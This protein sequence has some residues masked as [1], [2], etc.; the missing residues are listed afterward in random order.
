MAEHPWRH[1]GFGWRAGQ[2][3]MMAREGRYAN[4][5]TV[6]GELARERLERVEERRLLALARGSDELCWEADDEPEPLVTVRYTTYN[7]G[8]AIERALASALRQTYERLEVLVVGD[9]CDEATARAVQAVRDPRVRFVNLPVRGTYP[10]YPLYRW[11]IAGATPMNVAL[12]IASGK[13]IAPSDDDDELTDDHVEVL[14]RHARERRHEFVWSQAESE[15]KEMELHVV[16]SS[17]LTFGQIIHGTV[18]YST[19][20]RF[21]RYSPTSWKLVEGTDWNL[22]RRMQRAGVRMGFLP[23]VTYRKFQGVGQAG[24]P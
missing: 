8:P 13:W 17:P 2:L 7:R 4:P 15:N 5:L 21:L 18:L 14:L 19:K 20:L 9:H 23:R 10:E 22:W 6:A 11:M 1:R 3:R 16:G 24:R 12:E